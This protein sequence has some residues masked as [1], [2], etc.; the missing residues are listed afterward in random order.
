MPN[1]HEQP[2]RQV[3]QVSGT[4]DDYCNEI[5]SCCPLLNSPW[6]GR[7]SK[8]QVKWAVTED[9]SW[10][11]KR[12]RFSFS[13]KHP[14]PALYRNAV[15]G[16]LCPKGLGFANIIRSNDVSHRTVLGLFSSSSSRLSASHR[17]YLLSIYSVLGTIEHT[18]NI[19]PALEELTF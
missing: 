19:V 10:H 2:I 6:P 17:Q 7:G 18:E 15:L 16:I 9:A 4:T 12:M 3:W 8:I 1:A 11:H 5:T 13:S 14:P